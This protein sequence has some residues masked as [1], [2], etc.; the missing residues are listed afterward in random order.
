VVRRRH[1]GKRKITVRK[2]GCG[3]RVSRRVPSLSCLRTCEPFVPGG[4][5]PRRKDGAARTELENIAGTGQVAEK[6]SGYSQTRDR[7]AATGIASPAAT[8]IGQGEGIMNKFVAFMLAV[9]GLAGPAQAQ[10][11]FDINIGAGTQGGSQYP[12]SVALGTVIGKM[13]QI[14]RVTLQPGGSIGNIIRVDD[15]KS[16]I[17]I[18]MS[19]SLRD[20][21]LGKP[22]FKSKTENA[23]NLITLHAFHISI[24]V[25]EESS[26][27]TFKDFAGKK[28][29]IA[30]KG[31]SVREI[32]ERIA[33]MEGIAGKV[34]IGSLRITEAIESFKDGH[35][36]GLMYAP[37]E[38]FGPFMNLA[39]TRRIRLIQLEREIM[40][41][42]VKE[43]PSFYITKWPKDRSAYKYLSNS[44]DELAYPNVIAASAKL[45][46]DMAYAI[47]KQVAEHFD[48]IRPSEPSLA[49]FELK[50]MA[51]EVGTPFHPGA[52]KYYRERGWLK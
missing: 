13:P 50:N 4:N 18:S 24:F 20:G 21:R 7:R 46:D 15:G 22:P 51:L 10:G 49:N 26:I 12:I 45:S 8:R 23:L 33:K 25:P 6:L 5:R 9:A 3:V 52:A 43:D 41:A 38:R 36:D 28:L 17:A 39:E 44:V 31:F 42:F 30:P 19:Q 40:E 2:Q 11:K 34:D 1:G 16:D 32:G 29:N 14:G 27:K 47:V 35:Y 48:E 37:S